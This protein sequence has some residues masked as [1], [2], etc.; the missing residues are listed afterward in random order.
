MVT[1]QNDINLNDR[2]IQDTVMTLNLWGKTYLF[3]YVKPTIRP[4]SFER[5]ESII[6]NHI[7]DSKIGNMKLKDIKSYHIQRLLNSNTHMA[8]SSIKKIYQLLNMLFEK[9]VLNDLIHKNPILTVNMPKSEKATKEIEIL[10]REDQRKYVLALENEKQRPLFLTSLFMGI[11]MGELIALKWD[12]VDLDH[13]EITVCE[14]YKKTKVFNNDGTYTN[15]LIKQDPKSE[16]GKRKIPIPD[17][18]VDILQTH[19]VNQKEYGINKGVGFN[20]TNLA[21]C[22]EV[23]TPLQARNMYRIHERVC[24]NAKIDNIGFHALRHTFATRMIEKGVD[25]KTVQKWL[26]HSMIEITYNAYVHVQKDT[27]IAAAKMQDGFFKEL[28]D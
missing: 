21:F 22:S 15:Q 5:Y 12:N 13:K 18:L 24:S 8:K 20:P 16:S 14:S 26:G 6:R 17:F 1:L 19:T 10:S 2:Y 25:I 11:R 23:D 3:E 27:K 7:K 9:A 28:M 4:T